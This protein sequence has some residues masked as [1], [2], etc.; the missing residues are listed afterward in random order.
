LRSRGSEKT[1]ESTLHGGGNFWWPTPQKTWVPTIHIWQV[2]EDGDEA[3]PNPIWFRHPLCPPRCA[4]CLHL[5]RSP[6]SL[7]YQ[8]FSNWRRNDMPNY[9]ALE[10][11]I[12]PPPEN[13]RI[14]KGGG[15]DMQ[16]HRHYRGHRLEAPSPHTWVCRFVGSQVVAVAVA[17]ACHVAFNIWQG[18][19]AENS[20]PDF[21]RTLCFF[22]CWRRNGENDFHRWIGKR[23]MS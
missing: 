9:T 2:R 3:F 12:F 18:K 5:L 14:W 10:E 21:G 4:L 20:A 7:A 8:R 16:R 22:F 13:S 19:F 23:V 6:A 1:S 11:N 17:N 15:E